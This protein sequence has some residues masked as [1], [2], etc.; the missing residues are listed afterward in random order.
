MPFLPYLLGFSF[1][2]F[3]VADRFAGAIFPYA[4]LVLFAV[5][6]FIWAYLFL[7]RNIM[8]PYHLF[9]GSLLGLIFSMQSLI[10]SEGVFSFFVQN[11]LFYPELFSESRFELSGIYRNILYFADI[12]DQKNYYVVASVS[13][14]I[15]FFFITDLYRDCKDRYPNKASTLALMSMPMIYLV[16]RPQSGVIILLPFLSLSL[17]IGHYLYRS[18]FA[19]LLSVLHPVGWIFLPQGLLKANLSQ[20]GLSL[21]SFLLLPAIAFFLT[22]TFLLNVI[23]AIYCINNIAASFLLCAFSYYFLSEQDRISFRQKF[24]N[25][26]F[27]ICLFSFWFIPESAFPILSLVLI[28]CLPSMTSENLYLGLL[29]LFTGLTLSLSIVDFGPYKGFLPIGLAII[30]CIQASLHIYKNIPEKSYFKKSSIH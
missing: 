6:G 16:W 11:W 12:L 30:A 21:F 1:Y 24:A 28:L 20:I 22:N 23:K 15:S 2:Y 19:G 18:I 7:N 8:S 17:G 25:L 13:I 26:C 4:D 5:Q 29:G 10:H 14:L 3:Q 27:Y 9:F